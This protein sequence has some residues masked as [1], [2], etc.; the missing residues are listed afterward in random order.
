MEGLA[1]LGLRLESSK[2]PIERLSINHI[3]RPQEN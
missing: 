2:Q 1:A 3:E